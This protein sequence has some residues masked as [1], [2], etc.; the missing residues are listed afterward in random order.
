VLKSPAG[1][2]ELPKAMTNPVIPASQIYTQFS[3]HAQK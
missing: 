2:A 3:I 1:S